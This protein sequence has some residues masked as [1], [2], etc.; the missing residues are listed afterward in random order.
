MGS[1]IHCWWEQKVV[2]TLWETVWQLL[3]RLNT[4]SPYDPGFTLSGVYQ[5]TENTFTR[6]PVL[7]NSRWFYSYYYIK[8]W[9]TTKMS[10]HS[11]CL[12]KLG[13]P[14]RRNI[15]QQQKEISDTLNTKWP[16]RA[17][18]LVKK[19]DL[20]RLRTICFHSCGAYGNDKTTLRIN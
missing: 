16:S 1:L 10:C 5:K 15:A 2:Q 4:H 6:K 20:K 14:I 3:T 7:K 9:K 17:L 13:P 18:C 12:N 11:E 8:Y 19:A